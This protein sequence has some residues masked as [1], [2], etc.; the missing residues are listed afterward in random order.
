MLSNYRSN[1]DILKAMI[2]RCRMDVFTLY[3]FSEY[4]LDM[5]II[6]MFLS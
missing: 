3:E 5:H 6:L 4:Y 1:F 2:H